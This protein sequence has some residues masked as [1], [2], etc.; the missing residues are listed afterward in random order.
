MRLGYNAN[1]WM[2]LKNEILSRAS[3]YPSTFKGS[4]SKNGN[5]YGD[6]YEQQ[7]IVY[8]SKGKPANVIVGWIMENGNPRMTTALIKEMKDPWK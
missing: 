4:I 6:K 5:V 1:N 3:D 7:I 8:G 2:D